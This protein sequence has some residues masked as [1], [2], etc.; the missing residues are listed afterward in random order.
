MYAEDSFVYWE[1]FR[2]EARVRSEPRGARY[3]D[4]HTIN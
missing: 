2:S 3:N 4:V 1:V